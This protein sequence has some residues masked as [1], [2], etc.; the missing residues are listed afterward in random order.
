MAVLA[1]KLSGPFQSWGTTLKL[2]DHETDTM[3]SKSGVLGILAAAFGRRRD[4]D[5][6]DLRSLRFGVRSDAPGTLMRDFQT[7]HSWK[8]NKYGKEYA[9]ARDSY[10]GIRYYLQDACFTVGLE[11]E[12]EFLDQCSEALRHPVFPPYLG[13]RSCVP[14][15]G[16]VIGIFDGN[17]ETV[18]KS[19]PR[20]DRGQGNKYMRICVETSDQGDRMR[21]DNPI[22]YDFHNRQYAY[23]MEKELQIGDENDHQ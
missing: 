2:R 17:L 4:A 23:R 9:D 7:A 15:P 8:T 22:S 10:I 12:R 19:I 14:D 21:H 13:R 6:S 3:P 11:G 18:L 5:I 20:Q 16:L 1:L